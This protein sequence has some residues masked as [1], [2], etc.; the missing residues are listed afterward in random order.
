MSDER[1]LFDHTPDEETVLPGT[2]LPGKRRK[3]FK[4][5]TAAENEKETKTATGPVKE[6]AAAQETKSQHKPKPAPVASVPTAKRRGLDWLLLFPLLIMLAAAYGGWQ[7]YQSMIEPALDT[8]TENRDN[9]NVLGERQQVVLE[10]QSELIDTLKQQSMQD[11][12]WQKA[13]EDKIAA[14]QKRITRIDRSSRSQAL[15]VEIGGLIRQADRLIRFEKDLPTAATT[16]RLVDRLLLE[17]DDSGADYV[18][19]VLANDLQHISSALSVDRQLMYVQ[20]DQL[21]QGVD[22]WA[23]RQTPRTHFTAAASEA[24]D[25]NLQGIE[26]YGQALLARL[27]TLVII[28]PR[29][30]RDQP[31]LPPE[32]SW[33]LRENLR[34]QL[35]QA[36]WA[37]LHAQPVIF[38][39]SI[40]QAG[41]WLDQYFDPQ[42]AA[43]IQAREQLAALAGVSVGMPSVDIS[44]TQ[45]ALASYHFEMTATQQKEAGQ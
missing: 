19:G 38:D 31:M 17:L 45:K 6:G 41:Q 29:D 15:L 8:V 7:W 32:Q 23:L 21:S 40:K 24:V 2:G 16:L 9:L 11:M 22:E 1:D 4:A 5:S 25:E 10:Q 12:Q 44:A 3:S 42:Q 18:R 39:R 28:R 20:L 30:A 34:L 13:Q 35:Q 33:F 43:V 27:K 26:K 37:A 36:Q 14:L